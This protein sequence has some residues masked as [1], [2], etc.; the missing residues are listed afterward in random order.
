MAQSGISRRSGQR[1]WPCCTAGA[2]RWSTATG[3]TRRPGADSP[4]LRALRRAAAGA[5]RALGISAVRALDPRR[6]DLRPRRLGQQR[7]FFL[8]LMAFEALL[9]AEGALPVN[10][11]F[12]LEG[13]EELRAD[14]L[15]QLVEEQA[16][17]LRADFCRRLRLRLLRAGHPG[18]QHRAAGD[19]CAQLHAADC[20]TAT[21]T[22]AA[23]VGPSRMRSTP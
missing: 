11:K 9:E 8:Y 3:C 17:L 23:S 18:H 19:G 1:T 5:A 12:L 6:Q 10:V 7:Q 22:P 20:Q 16:E 21:S 2:T 14:H 13:E 4:G 15:A